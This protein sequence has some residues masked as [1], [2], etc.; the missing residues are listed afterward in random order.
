MNQA[1]PLSRTMQE[2]FARL[3]SL[4]DLA[5]ESNAEIEKRNNEEASSMVDYELAFATAFL[6]ASG[7]VKERECIAKQQSVGLYRKH[8]EAVA[9]RRSATAAA[10]TFHHDYEAIQALANAY[11][12]ELRVLGS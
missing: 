8:L 11:N 10:S 1:P 3:D 7:P 6:A 12:R 4:R 2:L 5:L 9:L